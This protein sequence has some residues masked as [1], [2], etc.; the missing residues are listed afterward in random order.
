MCIPI[1]GAGLHG[2]LQE[3]GAKAIL[4]IVGISSIT[5][6]ALRSVEVYDEVTGGRAF[7]IGEDAAGYIK[8]FVVTS[9]NKSKQ[10][11][12]MNNFQEDNDVYSVEINKKGKKKIHSYWVDQDVARIEEFD[13]AKDVIILPSEEVFNGATIQL[14]FGESTAQGFSSFGTIVSFG[15]N[16]L[17]F[18]SGVYPEDHQAT[19]GWV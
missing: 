14:G 12:E 7:F 10:K 8:S 4:A 17:A 11:K 18:T 6:M 2:M 19:I 1:T 5:T 16:I 3:F 9:K 15:Q 13:A